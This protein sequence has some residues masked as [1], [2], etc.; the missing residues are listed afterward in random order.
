MKTKKNDE[1][2]EYEEYSYCPT[3]KKEISIDE[4]ISAGA[5][6]SGCFYVCKFCNKEF[7]TR[8]RNSVVWIRKEVTQATAREIG[9]WLIDNPYA[10]NSEIREMI[11]KKWLG[12]KL[13]RTDV[14]VRLYA[15]WNS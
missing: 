8:K 11:N 1:R 3:C 7:E 14:L 9:K 10:T 12:E 5:P 2:I 6:I 15:S 4:W 13:L